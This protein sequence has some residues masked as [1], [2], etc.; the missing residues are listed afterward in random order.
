MKLS[1]YA[2]ATAF[3][4][5][6]EDRLQQ[7]SVAE[8]LDIQRLRRQVAFDRLLARL[9]HDENPPWLL[10]GGYAMELR[11]K[12]ARTTR[13]IDL[14]N[15]PAG[16]TLSLVKTLCRNG[17][18]VRHSGRHHAPFRSGA[19]LPPDNP[20][21]NHSGSMKHLITP[22]ARFNGRTLAP[23]AASATSCRAGVVWAD[24]TAPEPEIRK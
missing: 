3:R 12:F 15:S 18:G 7:W 4:R 17:K 21:H 8:T 2:S 1:R 6:L 14:A 11:L 19:N 5:A 20:G 22:P 23:R 9:F 10:K 24:S 13:D 16:A